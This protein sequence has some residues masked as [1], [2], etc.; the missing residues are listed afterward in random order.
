[1][2]FL[3]KGN[4]AT[5]DDCYQFVKL[6][7]GLFYTAESVLTGLLDAQPFADVPELANDLFACEVLL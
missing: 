4:G 6:K 3:E 5:H 7:D 2:R 1:M